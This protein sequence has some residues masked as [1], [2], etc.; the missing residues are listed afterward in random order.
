MTNQVSKQKIVFTIIIMLTI[1]VLFIMI[2]NPFR[3]KPVIKVLNASWSLT[4]AGYTLDLFVETTDRVQLIMI[5]IGGNYYNIVYDIYPPVTNVSIPLP[6]DRPQTHLTLHFDVSSPIKIHVPFKSDQFSVEVAPGYNKLLLY[7]VIPTRS[8]VV[9]TQIPENMNIGIIVN[10]RSYQTYFNIFN[11]VVPDA[12]FTIVSSLNTTAVMN[13]INTYNT[14]VFIDIAPDPSLLHDLIKRGKNIVLHNR[15]YILGEYR[16]SIVNGTLVE[17]R[18]KKDNPEIDYMDIPCII[19]RYSSDTI[20]SIDFLDKLRRWLGQVDGTYAVSEHITYRLFREVYVKDKFGYIYMGRTTKGFYYSSI[21]PRHLAILL[22]S[23]FFEARDKTSYMYL[24]LHPFKGLR[25]LN[26]PVENSR[27]LIY[28][29]GFNAVQ[30]TIVPPPIVVSRKS[31]SIFVSIGIDKY[32][33]T[34]WTNPTNVKI[35][36]ITYNGWIV[37]IK[38]NTYMSLPTILELP[39]Q[40]YIAYAIYVD[41]K[42]VY[43]IADE[44]TEKP[45]IMISNS[46]ICEMFYVDISR[47]D[48]YNNPLYLYINGR[49]VSVLYPGQSYKSTTC[50]LGYYSIEVRNIYGDIVVSKSFKVIRFYEQPLFILSSL[51]IISVITTGFIYT[52]RRAEKEV[53]NVTLILYRLPEK[54][55]IEISDEN[56][57]E[58]IRKIHIKRKIFPDVKEVAKYIYRRRPVTKIIPEVFNILRKIL[59]KKKLIMYSRYIPELDDTISIIGYDKMPTLVSD[60]YTRVILDMMKKFGG[61]SVPREYLRDVIDVDNVLLIGKNLLLLTYVTGVYDVDKEIRN[62]ID[63]AF[64]SFMMI[65][66]LKLPFKPIGFAIITENKYVKLINSYIDDILNGNREVA[67]K[68]L[69]DMDIFQR[70]IEASRDIWIKRYILVAVPLTRLAPLMAFTK[71]GKTR[72]CNHYYRFAPFY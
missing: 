65:R 1:I 70:I 25:V 26:A 64:T 57:I 52:Q 56:I 30:Y 69:R 2:V 40:E 6:I 66:R 4:S 44:V 48:Q 18:I 67:V 55:D 72:L 63:K 11:E 8:I 54:K 49:K 42:L 15:D 14:L 59:E 27:V 32:G 43:I 47:K 31:D 24:E 45:Y 61:S 17:I 16:I 21:G 23:G 33:R 68:L 5:E 71:T 58:I 38:Y 22:A 34:I 7:G 41:N 53:D 20:T 29:E 10:W 9:V 51:L 62:A 13:I 39:A 3:T 60:F 19:K 28:A 46:E 50:I 36:G 35:I 37:D 12:N